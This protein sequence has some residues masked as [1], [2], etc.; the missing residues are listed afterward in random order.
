M[1]THTKRA[2]PSFSL[3]MNALAKSTWI[4]I[5]VANAGAFFLSPPSSPK[6][7]LEGCCGD[8]GFRRA[9]AVETSCT[10]HSSIR[11]QKREQQTQQRRQGCKGLC[12]L[13][14]KKSRGEIRQQAEDEADND[15]M[16]FE[17]ENATQLEDFRLSKLGKWKAMI[18]SGEVW[19]GLFPAA[20]LGV[21]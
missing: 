3:A 19:Y 17:E 9:R 14:A 15:L 21:P 2:G 1:T 8:A 20:H 7:L 13:S 4:V 16:V 11:L 18:Q 6:V 10:H 12:S 5:T